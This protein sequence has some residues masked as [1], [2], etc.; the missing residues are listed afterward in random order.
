MAVCV[1]LALWLLALG[2]GVLGAGLAEETPDAEADSAARAES[3]SETTGTADAT[4]DEPLR[5]IFFGSSFTY[6]HDMPGTL[7]RLA[8]ATDPPFEVFEKIVAPPGY[9]LNLHWR[10]EQQRE[11]L[12]EPWDVMILQEQA[13]APL[14][15]RERMRE[16]AK[17]LVDKARATTG[18]E[19]RP[20]VI[21]FEVWAPKRRPQMIEILSNAYRDVAHTVGGEVAPVGR[22][23]RRALEQR[24]SLQLH[25]ADGAHPG[26]LGSY[27]TACVFYTMITGEDP[28]GLPSFDLQAPADDI[29]FVQQVAWEMVNP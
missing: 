7:Q 29:A 21:L 23:W 14:R 26:P 17:L 19:T 11:H 2:G 4:S 1:S 20:R 8:S 5:I 9:S 18:D 6:Y 15:Q 28:R 10:D 24:P 16:H 22:A 3:E 12:A 13:Q 27:L 25:S